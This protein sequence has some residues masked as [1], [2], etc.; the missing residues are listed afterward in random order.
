MPETTDS[1]EF[2]AEEV[3]EQA[4]GNAG[5]MFLALLAYARDQGRSPADAA[6]FVGR[7]FAPSWDTERGKGALA[8]MRWATLNLVTC[9]AGVR[10]L[11]GDEGRAEAVVTGWPLEE[12]LAYFGLSRE[13]ADAVHQLMI[14][15]AEYLGLRFA[16][17]RDGDD[18]V[19]TLEQTGEGT[20]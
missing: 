8:A 11:A 7:L 17:R 20:S 5:S 12:E 14:P 1:V 4:K 2:T 16:F 3:C 15:I 13:E 18:V 9:R 10:S 6:A 19:M